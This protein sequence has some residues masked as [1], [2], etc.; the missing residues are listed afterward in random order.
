ML[1]TEVEQW[2]IEVLFREKVLIKMRKGQGGILKELH[3]LKD[4]T[5]KCTAELKEKKVL[6]LH[7]ST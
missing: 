1:Q 3:Q 5:A 6:A 2:K 7:T 4:E